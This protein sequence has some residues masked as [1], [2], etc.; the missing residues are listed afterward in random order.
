MTRRW[1]KGWQ[2]A[3]GSAVTPHPGHCLPAVKPGA[4]AG[5]SVCS[6]GRGG[7]GGLVN[8]AMGKC[9]IFFLLSP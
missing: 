4:E 1:G 6:W 3:G 8:V 5:L 7:A 2:R 9:G